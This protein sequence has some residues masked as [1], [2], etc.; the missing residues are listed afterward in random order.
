[1]NENLFARNITGAATISFSSNKAK[2]FK[3]RATISEN[4]S[5]S[6]RLNESK[7]NVTSDN[8]NRNEESET[9]LRSE[10]VKKEHKRKVLSNFNNRK[11]RQIN[12]GIYQEDEVSLYGGS[13]LNANI[14]Q[15]TNVVSKSYKVGMGYN[16]APSDDGKFMNSVVNDLITFENIREPVLCYD[17]TN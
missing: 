4:P 5:I 3:W 6:T 15:L 16:T 12:W 9:N 17:Q 11:V 14:Q 8:I 7:E 1:M 13:D 10:Y 2:H